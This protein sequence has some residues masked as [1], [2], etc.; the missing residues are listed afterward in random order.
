MRKLKLWLLR[1][2]QAGLEVQIEHGSVLLMETRARLQLAH[3]QLRQTRSRIAEMTPARELLDEMIRRNAAANDTREQS[4]GE[5]ASRARQ[6]Y[7]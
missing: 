2:R 4:R 5:V 1:W 3:H 6:D 7:R